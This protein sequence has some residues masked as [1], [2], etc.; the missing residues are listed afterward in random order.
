MQAP[1]AEGWG[2]RTETAA[3]GQAGVPAHSQHSLANGLEDPWAAPATSNGS[4]QHTAMGGRR[5][6]G[7]AAVSWGPD[8]H[9][10]SRRSK[11]LTLDDVQGAF[12]DA[13]R[14]ALASQLQPA[15]AASSRSWMKPF[16]RKK[17]AVRQQED[18]SAQDGSFSASG[19]TVFTPSQLQRAASD[20]LLG[21]PAEQI[22]APDAEAAAPTNSSRRLWSRSQ[23]HVAGREL[24][25]SSLSKAEPASDVVERSKSGTEASSGSRW[26]LFNR[27]GTKSA[28]TTPSEPPLLTSGVCLHLLSKVGILALSLSIVG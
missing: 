5:S 20:T 17:K 28:A 9:A 24:R 16:G 22:T 27:G 6:D 19:R 2:G 13:R 25:V 21:E 3:N 8:A 4:Q 26:N 14:S 7:G 12:D 18:A 1:V 23:E 11:S 10:L 15:E